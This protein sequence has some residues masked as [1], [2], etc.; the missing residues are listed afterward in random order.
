MA[1]VVGD[2]GG[3]NDL[4]GAAALGKIFMPLFGRICAPVQVVFCVE[5]NVGELGGSALIAHHF[6]Q[7]FGVAHIAF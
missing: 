3:G 7:D 2:G 6:P 1:V 5:P 4:G